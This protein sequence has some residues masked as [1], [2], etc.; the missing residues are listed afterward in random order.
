[1][2]RQDFLPVLAQLVSAYHHFH[3]YAS[4]HIKTTSL[5]TTQFDVIATLGNRDAMTY[6][7]LGEQTLVTK[8]TLTGVI[9]RLQAKGLLTTQINPEDARSQLVKLTTEGQALFEQIFPQHMAHLQAAFTQLS[10]DEL[11]QLRRLL[12]RLQQALLSPEV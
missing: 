3:R 10:I 2:D 9:E 4:A 6:K 5:T 12:Q 11:Q 7:T 8:G 1:M